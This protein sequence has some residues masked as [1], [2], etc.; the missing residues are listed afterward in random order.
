MKT[1]RPIPYPDKVMVVKSFMEYSEDLLGACDKNVAPPAKGNTPKKGK[2]MYYDDEFENNLTAEEKKAI[3]LEGRLEGFLYEKQ[4]ELADRFGIL[5]VCGPKSRAEAT[6]WLK[7][8]RFKFNGV[9]DP[10]REDQFPFDNAIR[11]LQWTDPSK[12]KDAKGY[13]AAHKKLMK[14]YQ[15]ARDEILVK[16]PEEGLKVLRAFESATV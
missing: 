12:P 7:E 9:D 1:N 15:D 6:E 8:G 13:E 2:K 4:R 11:Y 3:H 14:L 16:T 10:D 5:G